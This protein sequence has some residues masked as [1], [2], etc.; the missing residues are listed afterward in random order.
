MSLPSARL[1]QFAA[2]TPATPTVNLDPLASPEQISHGSAAT[3]EL[4]G[5]LVAHA[6]Q[7]DTD[8]P[9]GQFCSQAGLGA[10]ERTATLMLIVIGGF[11]PLVSLAA[12]GLLELAQRPQTRAAVAADEQ[13]AAAFV[14]ELL[15]LQSPIRS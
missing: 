4:L 7:V 12:T 13:S 2:L 6:A 14:D 3:A 5:L 15:R 11:E 1:G 10:S 8:T 9:L